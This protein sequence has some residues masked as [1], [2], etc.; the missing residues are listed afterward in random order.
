MSIAPF[1]PAPIKGNNLA[2]KLVGTN[3]SQVGFAYYT[4]ADKIEGLGGNDTLEGLAG[5]DT[6]V[7]GS[8][9]DWIYGGSNNDVIYGDNTYNYYGGDADVLFGGLG[10]DTIYAGGGNDVVYG[11]EGNDRLYGQGGDDIILG[12]AGR[13]TLVGG[14]GNDRLDGY[15]PFEV[16][17]YRSRE[18]DRL[19]G[20]SGADTFVLGWRNS[21]Y[22]DAY[23]QGLGYATITDFNYQEGDKLQLFG[24]ANDY[25][26]QY[27]SWSGGSAQD[28]LVKYKNDIIAVIEDDTSFIFALDAD[29]V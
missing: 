29:F 23:Y 26:L 11:N 6:L 3:P 28:T 5:K 14:S 15:S 12:W 10:N 22:Q 17:A 27:T 19:T 8:G 20:G 18:Y 24:N 16:N 1:N 9:A 21:Y 7:G 25:S 2:N 4:G 13:D